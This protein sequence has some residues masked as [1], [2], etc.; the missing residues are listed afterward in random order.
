MK[1]ESGDEAKP[2]GISR[3]IR[4]ALKGTKW[5]VE[6]DHQIQWIMRHVREDFAD[7]I[8]RA[9]KVHASARTRIFSLRE[10][11]AWQ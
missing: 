9:N 4:A 5:E 6:A 2:K 8:S 1:Q 7:E 3:A 10:K 11:S